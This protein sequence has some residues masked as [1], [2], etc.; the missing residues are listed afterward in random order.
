MENR[1]KRQLSLKL[2]QQK[3]FFKSNDSK[4]SKSSSQ[5]L[6]TLCDEEA[7]IIKKPSNQITDGDTPSLV[8]PSVSQAQQQDHR[9]TDPRYSGLCNLGNTCYVNSVLQV[10][11]F[12]PKFSRGV[13]D[14]QNILDSTD[15]SVTNENPCV[16]DSE[17]EERMS[18]NSLSSHLCKVI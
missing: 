18:S 17:G 1:P 3:L 10:L 4:Q 2:G 15:G 5:S 8:T 14:M 12:C 16:M 7:P 13:F 6:S 9:S 11:R